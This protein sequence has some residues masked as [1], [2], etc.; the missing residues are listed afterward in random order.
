MT[1][2]GRF[3]VLSETEYNPS[4]VTFFMKVSG[5]EDRGPLTKRSFVQ[6][7]KDRKMMQ[8]HP[9]FQQTVSSSRP[10]Y[11]EQQS[12]SSS[13]VEDNDLDNAISSHVS[14]EDGAS[15][16]TFGGNWKRQ[17]QNRIN[18]LQR[19]TWD[20]SDSLW[21]V[22]ITPSL[23][24]GAQ[25]QA[26]E[27]DNESVLV[28]RGHHALADGASMGAAL[29]DLVD[30][31]DDIRQSIADAYQNY[32]R[33]R[34][35]GR[36]TLWQRMYR[37]LLQLIWF[38]FGSLQA[39]CYQLYLLF[40]AAIE[41]NPWHQLEERAK[42]AVLSEKSDSSRS[43][44][45][46]WTGA[47]APVEQ[48]KWVA[49]ELLGPK[50]T[51]NDVFVSCV[52][53][54]LTRQ[55]AYHRKKLEAPHLDEEMKKKDRLLFLPKQRHM[56]VS[57][58]VHLKGGVI[59]PGESVGNN[60]GA[61]VVRLPGETKDEDPVRRFEAV[62][63]SLATVKRTPAPL[64]SNMLA[65]ALSYGSYVI[66]SSVTSWLF[67]R[68]NAGSVAVVTNTRGPMS[69]VHLDGRRI[70]SLYGFIPLPPCIPVGVVVNSYAGNMMLT[71]TAQSWA[72]PDG[73]QFLAWVLEEYL[74]LLDIACARDRQRNEKAT[75]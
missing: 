15:S 54:A 38:V 66:P 64:L 22:Y 59:L 71:L 43:R 13:T 11:F 73:D 6:L 14:E 52:T 24:T 20:I 33:G 17:M 63:S 50:A 58:P 28:F 44:T 3:S 72:V 57:V 61:F 39:I 68:A 37:Q 7:W 41:P 19:S 26:E 40:C 31:A 62:H 75:R 23:S 46:S 16:L 45:V 21:H 51:V 5:T 30:E 74:S 8:L 70:E 49:R 18:Y 56:N 65:K 35:R 27:N 34:R 1:A 12:V 47:A 25:Q 29:M 55:L 48:V 67:S 53:A 32:R 36:S 42:T 60:L 2:I 9:R 69:F 4:I 10:G